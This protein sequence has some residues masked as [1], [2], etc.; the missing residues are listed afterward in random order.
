MR[1]VFDHSQ[2]ETL[3]QLEDLVH[4]AGMPAVVHDDDRAR[5]GPDR[6]F[7]VDRT[8]V[9]VVDAGN[10][11]EDRIR[12]G[13]TN[14]VRGG[15][16][17]E[18]REEHLVTRAAASGEQREMQGRG[19]VRDG[20]RMP[21]ATEARELE[22]ELANPRPHSPPAGPKRCCHGLFD[23]V[24]DEDIRQRDDPA[25]FSRRRHASRQRHRGSALGLPR[26]HGR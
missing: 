26:L 6:C 7:E 16:E 10:V 5:P 2:P 4:P 18:R 11:T 19:A 21:H 9:Q 22:L 17:I 8:D 14:R 1:G 3:S 15:N 13:V 24:V 23:L 12:A 20:K 25:L